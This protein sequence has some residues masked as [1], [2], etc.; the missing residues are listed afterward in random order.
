MCRCSSRSG[1]IC[2]P[3]QNPSSQDKLEEA[4]HL[5]LR[6]FVYCLTKIT[7]K[8]T[9]SVSF[10]VL[11]LRIKDAGCLVTRPSISFL[12]K[13]TPVGGVNRFLKVLLELKLKF[14]AP[15]C[16]YHLLILTFCS[17]WFFRS[18]RNKTERNLCIYLA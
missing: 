3:K 12:C 1:S 4:A 17:H 9:L 6:L 10:Q 7:D 5:T 18:E 16:G 8:D 2:Q 13:K 15:Q 11:V 14:S